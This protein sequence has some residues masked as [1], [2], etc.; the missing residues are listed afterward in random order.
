[1]CTVHTTTRSPDIMYTP[2][3]M[4]NNRHDDNTIGDDGI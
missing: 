4:L 1:L 2:T 3:D